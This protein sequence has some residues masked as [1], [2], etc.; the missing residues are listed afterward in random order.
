M[1]IPGLVSLFTAEFERI[2]IR[3]NPPTMNHR[4][5]V[6]GNLHQ[7]AKT[8]N[9]TEESGKSYRKSYPSETESKINKNLARFRFSG[10][11]NIGKPIIITCLQDKECHIDSKAATGIKTEGIYTGLLDTKVIF[12]YSDSKRGYRA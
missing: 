10:F 5:D 9:E 12:R 7:S 8:K 4:G 11:N 6:L 2:L 1:K 3:Y